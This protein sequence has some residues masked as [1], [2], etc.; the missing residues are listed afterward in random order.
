AFALGAVAGAAGLVGGAGPKTQSPNSLVWADR[1][2]VNRHALAGWLEARGVAFEAWAQR[3]PAAV[4]A[5]GDRSDRTLAAS[6]RSRLD[7][8]SRRRTR[9]RHALLAGLLA[10]LSLAILLVIYAL[11]A[12]IARYSSRLR[13]RDIPRR[14]R[15]TTRSRAPSAGFRRPIRLPPSP[16]AAA[17]RRAWSLVDFARPL[18]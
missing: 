9:Q 15:P 4:R 11:R 2:F 8:H 7:E 1:V 13:K 17:R 12:R 16:L 6:S 10:G 14:R 5:F 3:H 18:V